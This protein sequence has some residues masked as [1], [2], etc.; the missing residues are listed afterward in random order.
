MP[1]NSAGHI[2]CVSPL[3]ELDFPYD[4]V[5]RPACDAERN[6]AGHCA[7]EAMPE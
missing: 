5:N 4:R 2:A 6:K 7:V 1:V 3:R